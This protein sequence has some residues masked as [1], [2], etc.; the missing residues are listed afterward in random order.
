MAVTPKQAEGRS[1]LSK[2]DKQAVILYT[3]KFIMY[4]LGLLFLALGVTASIKSD[5]GVSPLNSMPYVL[6][7]IT[8]VEMGLV[9]TGIFSIFILVQILIL[10]R[11]FKIINL[12]QLP[13][14]SISGYFIATTN[15][16]FSGAPPAQNMAV[17]ILLLGIS[18][19]VVATGLLF[20]LAAE[21]VPLPPEGLML[22]LTQKTGISFH[23]TKVAVDCGMVIV[24]ALMS[25]VAYG[26][27]QGVGIGTILSAIFI[28]K[29]L[30]IMNRHLKSKLTAVLVRA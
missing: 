9:V 28:G 15:G 13:F 2:L 18:I 11:D 10:R 7:R 1:F 26:S 16:W 29:T 19:V 27:L 17:R 8:G 5:L 20:Y 21:I 3:K 12:L 23:N 24:A 30:G 6:G 22:A 14:A 4:T 25:L